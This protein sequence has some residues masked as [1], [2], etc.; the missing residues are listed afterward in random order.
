VA[1]HVDLD[2]VTRLMDAG[3]GRLPTLVPRLA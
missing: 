3:P 1:E 2:A